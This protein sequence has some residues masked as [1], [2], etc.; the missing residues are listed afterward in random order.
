MILSSATLKIINLHFYSL[1]FASLQQ[2]LCFCILQK[3]HLIIKI[4]IFKSTIQ[5]IVG[6]EKLKINWQN[7]GNMNNTDCSLQ[8]LCICDW[9]IHWMY[10]HMSNGEKKSLKL[11]T[12]NLSVLKTAITQR[13]HKTFINHHIIK[14]LCAIMEYSGCSYAF[15]T[16][17]INLIAEVLCLLPSFPR[18]LINFSIVFDWSTL[19]F[20]HIEF[21]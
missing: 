5:L 3:I 4:L 7:S 1:N 21:Y 2:V 13:T 16:R 11:I 12:N 15:V 6:G 17:F 14:T 19:R 8:N 9:N 18:N 10:A 20:S